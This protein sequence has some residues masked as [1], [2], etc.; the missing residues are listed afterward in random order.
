MACVLPEAFVA[1]SDKDFLQTASQWP[2]SPICALC[3]PNNDEPASRHSVDY[4]RASTLAQVSVTPDSV[5]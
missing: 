4:D 1:M 3:T 5:K 2:P